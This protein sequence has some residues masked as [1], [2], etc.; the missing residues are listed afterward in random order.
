MTPAPVVLTAKAGSGSQFA[1]WSG[2]CAA[3][4]LNTSCTVLANGHVDV[5]A[6]FTLIPTSGGGGGGG[7]GGGMAA[8]VAAAVAAPR[9]RTSPCR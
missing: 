2:G 9:R 4:G 3:A 6:M 5:G 8:V 7:G 1:G